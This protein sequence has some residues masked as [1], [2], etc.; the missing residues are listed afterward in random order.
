MRDFAAQD[1]FLE[2]LSIEISI[3]LRNALLHEQVQSHAAELEDRVA[4]RTADLAIAKNRAEESDR[5]KSAFLAT[6]SHELRTP[7]NSVIGFTGILLQ[8]LAGP[9][10][11]E[12]AKQLGMVKNSARHLLELIN[13]VLDISKIEAGQLEVVP[14]QFDMPE[15]VMAVVNGVGPLAEGKGLTLLVDV[16]SHVGAVFSDKRRVEQILL[17]LLNNAIKFTDK[18]EVRIECEA[19][20]G[21]IVTRISDTGIGIRP[22]DLPGVFEPFRQVDTGLDRRHEGTGLGLAICRKLAGALGGGIEVESK[23]GVG[24]TFALTIPERRQETGE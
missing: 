8:G 22:E 5:L 23:L 4:K 18:G 19:V 21:Q 11:E 16:S 15:T 13:D 7:L 10:N 17:N 12:Q 6:M 3:A 1:T 14:E 20:R 9:F 24:S 2:A